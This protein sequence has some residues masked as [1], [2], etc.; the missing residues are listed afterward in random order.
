MSLPKYN[1]WI[2][3]AAHMITAPTVNITSAIKMTGFL[4]NLSDKGPAKMAPMVAPS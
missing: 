4:P 3:G 2:E 1:I